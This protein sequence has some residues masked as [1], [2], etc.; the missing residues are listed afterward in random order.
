MKVILALVAVLV[1]GMGVCQAKN[2]SSPPEGAWKDYGHRYALIIMGPAGNDRLYALYWETCS[3]QYRELLGPSNF[4][5]Q[6]VRFLSYGQ[7]ARNHGAWIH[8]EPTVK[9]VKAAYA[10]AA[11]RCTDKDLLYIYWISHGD[12]SEFQL[13]KKLPHKTLASWMKP[14][15]AKVIIGVYQP[16]H[17]GAVIDDISGP[18][19]ITLTST[20]STQFNNYP[21]AENVRFALLNDPVYMN[22]SHETR[23]CSFQADTDGDGVVNLLEAY[24]RAAKVYNKERPLLDDN[25]DGRGSN[26]AD[27]E[28][29]PSRPGLDGYKSSRYSLAGWR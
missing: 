2:P 17:S 29:D 25:G 18:N 22:K 15:K 14:I 6:N 11:S 9:N 5:N 27:R 13:D 12:R 23:P 7:G 20:D 16:C 1:L 24:V 3:S 21:W 4:L 10:W 26:M 8:G 28:W 19:V